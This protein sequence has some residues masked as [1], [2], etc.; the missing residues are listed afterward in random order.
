MNMHTKIVLLAAVVCN[1]ALGQAPPATILE[2][3]VENIVEYQSD[4]SDLS[5]IAT[6]PNGTPAAPPKNFFVAT[7]LGDIV[8]VNGQPALGTCVTDALEVSLAPIPNAGHI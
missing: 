7:V 1:L 8:A 2:V 3:D 5:K 6:N 4:I